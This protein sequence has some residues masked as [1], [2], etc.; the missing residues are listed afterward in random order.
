MPAVRSAQGREELVSAREEGV[1]LMPGW[2]PRRMVVEDGHVV[3][4]ELM[5]C[6]RVFDDAGRFRPQFDEQDRTVVNVDSV[7]FAIGQAPELSF[8]AP[9]GHLRLPPRARCASIR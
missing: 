9:D 8:M 5:R 6:V 2:G 4:L 3:G 1:R 7:V